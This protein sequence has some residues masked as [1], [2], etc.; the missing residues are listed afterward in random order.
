[1]TSRTAAGDDGGAEP[2]GVVGLE[3]GVVELRPYTT[4]WVRLFEE[5]KALLQ[6]AIG[7]H[8][9]DIQHVGS[10]AIPGMVAKPIID[11]AVAVESFEGARVCIEPLERLG[12][13]YRGQ[14]G[15]PRRHYFT[16]GSPRTHH[17]HVNEIGGRDWENQVLFR[18][19]VIQHPKL[20]EEYAALKRELARK[21][22]RDRD[23]YLEG[24]APFIERALAMAREE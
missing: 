3:N 20:A 11:I 14:F 15:I 6:A 24:K 22:Q 5:E 2:E 16:K 21:H 12:Y 10:T 23:G 19:Y 9:L 13:C 7:A 4:E 8:V 18:D 17:V 1:M